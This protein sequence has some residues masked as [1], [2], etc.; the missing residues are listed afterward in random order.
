MAP[1]HLGL[2]RHEAQHV[3]HQLQPQRLG[4]SR[5]VQRRFPRELRGANHV[6][7]RE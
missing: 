3:D 2:V 4:R 7:V 1:A 6:I 5:V